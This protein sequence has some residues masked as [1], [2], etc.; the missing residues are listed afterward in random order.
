MLSNMRVKHQNSIS[1]PF[2]QK[3]LE[4][5]VKCSMSAAVSV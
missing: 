1:H 2:L 4:L 3:T 5:L